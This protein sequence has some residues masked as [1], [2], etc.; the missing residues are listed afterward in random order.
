[1]CVWVCVCMCVSV[2]VCVYGCGCVCVCL[3]VCLCVCVFVCV[4]VCGGRM[5]ICAYCTC[6]A[7]AMFQSVTLVTGS[8]SLLF[9]HN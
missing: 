8:C 1:M 7:E 2:C 9:L 3:C 4:C 6:V 5:S